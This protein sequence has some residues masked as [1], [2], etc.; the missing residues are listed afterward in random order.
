MMYLIKQQEIGEDLKMLS[1]YQRCKPYI[2][3]YQ[4]KK[5][6]ENIA[7]GLTSVG[8]VRKTCSLLTTGKT[9]K[10][11]NRL[12]F[13]GKISKNDLPKLMQTHH[14]IKHVPVDKN[15]FKIKRKTAWQ[16]KTGKKLE[17]WAKIDGVTKECIRQRWRR[18]K[19]P[20]KKIIGGKNV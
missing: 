6:D 20:T 13:T 8:S 12:F 2:L 10:E 16:I 3:K 15:G 4:R 7:N 17:E 11:W 18:H 5:R 14:H 19:S 1:N 9:S